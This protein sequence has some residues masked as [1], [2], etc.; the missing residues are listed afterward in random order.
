MLACRSPA[1]LIN[2]YLEI[3][4]SDILGVSSGAS[5]GAA[6]GI[7]LSGS[8]F[9]IQGFSLGFEIIAVGLVVMLGRVQRRTQL[10]TL[11]LAGVV[12]SSLFTALVSLIKYVSD[13]YD[14]LPAITTW[15]M[16][17]LASTSYDDIAV[18][19]AVVIPCC[20]LLFVLRRKLNLLSLDEEEARSL[21]V[22]V[23][24][25]RLVVIFL[26]MLITATTVS[27]CSVIGWVGLVIPH[28][29]R[30][31]VGNDHRLL[32]PASMLIGGSYMLIIDDIA[33]ALT[34]AEIPLSILTAVVGA[35]FFAWILRRTSNQTS[36]RGR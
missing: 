18:A 21:G 16:G 23:T 35:P 31:I 20:A 24:R 13:P 32:I 30:M 7:L 2:R 29:G 28:I 27:L 19:A 26:A 34:T 15:L 36:S 14:K 22:N 1:L 11:V 17:S 12:V 4:S 25:L 9:V 33:R 6:L 10:Y 5:F 8:A 3:L